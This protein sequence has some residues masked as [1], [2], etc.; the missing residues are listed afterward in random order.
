MTAL[1]VLQ[2]NMT[3]T[4]NL[5]ERKASEPDKAFLRFK[6]YRE[7]GTKRSLRDLA[8][9]ENVKLSAIAKISS[10]FNWKVRVA[11]WD[12]HIDKIS[13]QDEIDEI[14]AMK[15][16]QISLALKAQ[17]VAAQSL[18]ILLKQIESS[19][20][21]ENHLTQ[22]N[23]MNLSKFLDIGCR[24]ERLNRDE[25]EQNLVLIPQ[26]NYDNLSL[27]ELETLRNLIAKAEDKL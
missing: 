22:L 24:L 6:R 12:N 19:D 18:D 15:K 5:W 2:V 10:Q 8:H 11:A 17:K 23:L 4:V 1:T 26:T 9:E 20:E 7:M 16:R 21:Q 27:E 14:C 3:N 25:P 13:Q